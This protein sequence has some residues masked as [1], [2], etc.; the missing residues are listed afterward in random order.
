MIDIGQPLR[1]AYF[2]QL[3]GIL[4][5]GGNEIPV[6]DEKLDVQINEH[7]IY[8][9]MMDQIEDLQTNQIKSH[10]SNECLLRLTIVNQRRATNTKEIVEDISGQILNILFPDKA[11]IN[12]SLNAPLSLIYARYV[13]GDYQPLQQ[14][15]KGFIIT[16]TLTFKNRVIQS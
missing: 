16:K 2:Q 8:V 9:M 7:D 10:W 3:A 13:N 6:V 11:T 4:L 5:Y 12:L 1:K 14:N 15:T